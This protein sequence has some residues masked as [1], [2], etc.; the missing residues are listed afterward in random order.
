M[1]GHYKC[2]TYSTAL[3]FARRLI[4]VHQPLFTLLRLRAVKKQLHDSFAL[5]LIP[6]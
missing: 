1:F 2:L 5:E 3:R 6:R 4:L